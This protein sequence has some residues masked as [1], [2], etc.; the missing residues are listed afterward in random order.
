MRRLIAMMVLCV[1][2]AML[3]EVRAAGPKIIRPLQEIGVFRVSAMWRISNGELVESAIEPFDYRVLSNGERIA[4]EL[5]G[6]DDKR[7][8][9]QVYRAGTRMIV[10][11]SLD[12]VATAEAMLASSHDGGTLRQVLLTPKLLRI[13]RMPVNSLDIIVIEARKITEEGD[14]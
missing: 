3:G 14:Q 10:E 12:G 5:V 8:S 11:E 13:T 1:A 4:L 9:Y 6:S 2:G 7:L